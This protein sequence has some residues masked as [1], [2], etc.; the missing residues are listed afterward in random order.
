MRHLTLGI[1][2]GNQRTRLA[3]AEF[4]LSEEASA[5]PRAQA[6]PVLLLQIRRQRL[7][8]PQIAAQSEIGWPPPQR[9]LRRPCLVLAQTPRPSWPRALT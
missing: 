8:V 6:Y 4:P 7:A 5:L 9:H 2:A 1:G 3:Q